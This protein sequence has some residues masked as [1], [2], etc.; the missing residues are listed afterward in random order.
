MSGC[1]ID[2]GLGTLDSGIFGKV[3]FINQEKRPDYVEAVRIVAVVNLPPK[4]LGD[5][6]ITNSSVN[7]SRNES[8][9]GIPAPLASYEMVAAVWKKKGAAWDYANILSFYGY[10]PINVKFEYKPVV[11]TEK[12]PQAEGIDIY[13]DW[14]FVMP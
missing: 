12:K 11:L 9:Y 1:E 4:S 10:D 8:E 13:C 3:I 6:V 7:L 2:H 14:T 5:V